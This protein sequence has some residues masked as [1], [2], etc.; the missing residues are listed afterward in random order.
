MRM[1]GWPAPMSWV[2]R[3]ACPSR[4]DWPATGGLPYGPRDGATPIAGTAAVRCA[5]ARRIAF[6]DGFSGTNFREI[7]V[8][9]FRFGALFALVLVLLAVLPKGA[10]A[11]G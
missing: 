2:R 6:G 11:H 4:S 1:V 8:R 7:M 10:F 5:R 9:Q 3:W